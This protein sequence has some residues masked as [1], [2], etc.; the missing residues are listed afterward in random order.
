M[1]R[2]AVLAGGP[3]SEYE[4]S[5]ETGDAMGELLRAAGHLIQPVHVSR[6]GAWCFGEPDDTFAQ[7]VDLPGM[8]EDQALRRLADHGALCVL[9]LH[10]TFGEDGQIQRRLEQRG[11][12]FTGSGSAASSLAMDKVLTKARASAVGAAVAPH[13]VGYVRE[14]WPQALRADVGMPCIVKPVHSG[15]SVGLSLVR[16][17]RALAQAIA[18]AAAE[19]PLGEAMIE[20]YVPGLEVS[21][22]VLRVGGQV[23]A[24][25]IVAIEPASGLYDYHAKYVAHDTVI[26]CPAPLPRA[27]AASIEQVSRRLHV[28]LALRGVVRVDFR[29]EARTQ[30]PYFLELNTLPGFT[31]HSLVPRAAD[32]SGLGRAAVLEAVVDEARGT[33]R[34]RD[35]G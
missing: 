17:P 11:L 6:R 21:C 32:A 33:S 13:Q 5:L 25:P 3:S 26:T 18:C 24:L 35:A 16:E 19:D 2:L 9:A 34:A 7:L 27:V 30:T 23:R 20:R 15:S 14:T 8:T 1:T 12:P 4:V 28:A 29:V 22:A 10:G 31:S